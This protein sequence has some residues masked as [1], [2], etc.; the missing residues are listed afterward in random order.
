MRGRR[1]VS[2]REI[3]RL[4]SFVD[5]VQSDGGSF[6]QGMR[7]AV[8]AM[9]VS[10]QFLF[11]I[12]RDE[13]PRNPDAM[14]TIDPF[15]LASRMSYFLWSSMPDDT[16]FDAARSG[17]L[18]DPARLPDDLMELLD[19]SGSMDPRGWAVRQ[20]SCIQSHAKLN[21]C[22]RTEAEAA[23]RPWTTDL[24]VP[25]WRPYPRLRHP[26]DHARLR[27]ALEELHARWP[28]VFPSALIAQIAPHIP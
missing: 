3:S 28:A 9:L 7:L 26:T 14:H 11:R 27:P 19:A 17:R 20:V 21:R 18:L 16:L 22:V 10:P 25:C 24:A 12:E 1:P 13:S 6:E 5:Y 23:G 8:E 4:V 15:E 2:R